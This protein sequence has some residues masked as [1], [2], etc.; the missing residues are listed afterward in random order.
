[1]EN[2]ITV[3]LS[4]INGLNENDLANILDSLPINIANKVNEKAK[5]KSKLLRAVSYKML[6]D[7][8]GFNKGNAPEIKSKEN[9]KPYFEGIDICFSISHSKTMA[10]L[11]VAPT[12]VGIDIERLDKNRDY[13]DLAKRYFTEN[14]YERIKES[15]D[16]KDTF[17]KYWTAKEAYIKYT[18][19]GFKNGVK[20]FEAVF[21]DEKAY[22]K[23][24]NMPSLYTK[25]IKN[26]YYLSLVFE[27]EKEIE[28][29][30][31]KDL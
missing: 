23:G 7:Y 19:E 3:L 29:I 28:I 6:L 14:E 8:C 17:V 1:M 18:G 22:Y 12:E 4:D 20:Y 21:E 31:R 13:L 15:T 9:G 27:G 30:K 2:K 11:A 10:A 24:E 5:L 25:K 26:E 16:V